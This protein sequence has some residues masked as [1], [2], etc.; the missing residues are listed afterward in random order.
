MGHVLKKLTVIKFFLERNDA[1]ILWTI[2]TSCY[3]L[4]SISRFNS[5]SYNRSYANMNLADK[6]K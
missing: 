2:Y 6:W 3:L 4:Y 1:K 5:I